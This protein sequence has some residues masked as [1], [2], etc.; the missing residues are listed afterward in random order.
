[1]LVFNI[2]YDYS[3]GFW[4]FSLSPLMCPVRSSDAQKHFSWKKPVH[5][6]FRNFSWSEDL[7]RSLWVCSWV[8]YHWSKSPRYLP[9]SCCMAGTS[10]CMFHSWE[11]GY[12][13]HFT[14]H[15]YI[16]IRRGSIQIVSFYFLLVAQSAWYS[17]AHHTWQTRFFNMSAIQK[18]HIGAFFQERTSAYLNKL[19]ILVS[20]VKCFR[21]EPN[22]LTMYHSSIC[23]NIL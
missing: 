21:T 8:Y 15:L 2:K 16:S 3:G 9:G 12:C 13:V 4:P 6:Y 10:F 11:G 19:T 17:S 18:W 23:M 1:M 14:T 5:I 22:F 7:T 20:P